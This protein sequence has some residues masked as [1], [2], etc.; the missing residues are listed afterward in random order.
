[1]LL[2]HLMRAGAESSNRRLSA[3]SLKIVQCSLQSGCERRSTTQVRVSACATCHAHLG[4]SVRAR[5]CVRVTV[6]E[7]VC[8]CV[9]IVVEEGDKVQ[10]EFVATLQHHCNMRE[11]VTNCVGR[12]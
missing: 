1:M 3:F 4:N 7:C 2:A 10:D 6:S 12:A 5:V 11:L 9:T 8:A